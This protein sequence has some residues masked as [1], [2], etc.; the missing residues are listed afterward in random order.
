MGT[1]QRL[2]REIINKGMGSK[3][4]GTMR[5]LEKNLPKKGEGEYGI[6]SVAEVKG[7]EKK[8]MKSSS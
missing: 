1:S 5:S 4:L 7:R 2:G 6:V 8:S 3:I